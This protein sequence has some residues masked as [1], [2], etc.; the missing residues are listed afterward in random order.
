MWTCVSQLTEGQVTFVPFNDLQDRV[1]VGRENRMYEIYGGPQ[2]KTQLEKQFPQEQ[3][4]LDEFFRLLN[5]AY[6]WHLAVFGMKLV[7]MWLVKII[8][9]TG[10]IRLMTRSFET[11]DRTLKDVIENVT[12]NKDLREVLAFREVLICDVFLPCQMCTLLHSNINILK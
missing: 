6:D 12:D 3:K 8:F 5:G 10:L 2:W 9:R 7:P 11:R 4:A 1:Y